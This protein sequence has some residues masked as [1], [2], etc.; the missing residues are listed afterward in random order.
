G[1][2][3]AEIPP[4]V[5][6]TYVRYDIEAI[7]NNTTLTATYMPKGAEHDVYIYQVKL[8]SPNSNLVINELMAS[9]SNTIADGEGD[10]DDWVE[11]FNLGTNSID[12]SGYFLS[13]DGSELTKWRFPTGTSIAGGSYLTIWADNDA[14][15]SSQ[16]ELHADFKLSASGET[17]YLLNSD[18]VLIDKIGFNTQAS[19]QGF[20]RVPN[21]IG[22]FTQQNPTFGINNDLATPI[23]PELAISAKMELYPNPSQGVLLLRLLDSRVGESINIYDLNGRKVANFAAQ[24]QMKLDLTHLP[25]GLYYVQY[26]G[27]SKKLVLQH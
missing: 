12:L 6:G 14:S 27:L 24:N 18:T 19:D 26:Q 10:F 13:D 1:V 9:N 2:Y 11:L 16:T 17:L 4:F 23:E 25:S 8:N 3:G 20:A 21:G 5:A 22:A 7:A 15:Q